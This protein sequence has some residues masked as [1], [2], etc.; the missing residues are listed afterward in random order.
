MARYFTIRVNAG[1]IEQLGTATYDAHTIKEVTLKRSHPNPITPKKGNRPETLMTT[2]TR[3]TPK[4][5][6]PFLFEGLTWREF[7]AVEQLLD[8]PGYRLSFLDGVLERSHRS[9]PNG[10]AHWGNFV[11][12]T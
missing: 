10:T 12:R 2:A 9:Y 4:S 3:A 8:R 11:A 1:V 7:K 5:E 6:E